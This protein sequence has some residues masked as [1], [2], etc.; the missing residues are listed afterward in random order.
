MAWFIYILECSGKRL[1]TGIAK[2]VEKR[3]AE[4]K[5]GKGARFT[6]SFPPK[7]LLKVLEEATHGDAVNY[8]ELKQPSFQ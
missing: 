3:L 8:S 2:D 4:H 6:K 7:K 1:Y 5:A